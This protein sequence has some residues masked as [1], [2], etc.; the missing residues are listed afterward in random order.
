[1]LLWR[2]IVVFLLR[3]VSAIVGELVRELLW[4]TR[5]RDASWLRVPGNS[6]LPLLAGPR[7]TTQKSYLRALCAF[8]GWARER[9]WSWWAPEDV[10]EVMHCY[11]DHCPLIA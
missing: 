4:T 5:K 1:M 7:P 8:D 2:S 6:V 3:V 11:M 10:D 9:A